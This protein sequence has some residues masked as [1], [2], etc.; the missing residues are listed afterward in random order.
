ME[1]DLQLKGYK[2]NWVLTTF[3]I[4]YT[5]VEIPS[6]IILKRIGAKI[7]L[8]L[9]TVCFGIVCVGTAFVK[10]F[11]QLIFLRFLL[12]LTE[13]GMMPGTS[14]YLSCF[15]K[16]EELL[17]RIGVFATSASLA[18]AFGG[19]LATGLTKIPR[20]GSA[21]SELHTWRNIF[22]FEGFITIIIG[23][24]APKFL[25]RNPGD[26]K[27]LNEKETMIAVQRLAIEHRV[28]FVI[29]TYKMEPD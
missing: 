1:N 12:G 2:F 17:F 7:W 26:C 14:F 16:R 9:L 21:G 28:S 5:A 20:W 10:T 19:L 27:F 13:G 24:I 6:N 11:S 4:S 18:G 3:Y 23:L 25:P 22:F 29:T 15:Y 8:P